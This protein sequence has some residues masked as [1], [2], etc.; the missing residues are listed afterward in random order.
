LGVRCDITSEMPGVCAPSEATCY[1]PVVGKSYRERTGTGKVIRD[2]IRNAAMQERPAF[3]E[4]KDFMTA[5]D[6]NAGDT[7]KFYVGKDKAPNGAVLTAP[8]AYTDKQIRS[9]LQNYRINPDNGQLQSAE[10][11]GG[12]VGGTV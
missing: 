7:T 3:D 11:A 4:Y 8:R 6:I 2:Q 12:F 5:I 1:D 10:G 9:L